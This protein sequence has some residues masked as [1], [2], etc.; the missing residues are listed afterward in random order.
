VV[1]SVVHVAKSEVPGPYLLDGRE[2]G[3]ITA[4]LFHAGGHEDPARLKANEG[5]SFI[6]SY[7]L[8]MGFTFDD[9]DTKGVAT[10]LA[11]MERLIRK[12]PRNRE[13]VFPSIG[14]EEVNDSP[15]HAHQFRGLSAAPRKPRAGMGGGRRGP[16]QGV[17]ARWRCAGGLCWRA[18][19]MRSSRTSSKIWLDAVLRGRLG[20]V[21]SEPLA[22]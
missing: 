20:S 8:G 10:P 21:A 2:V 18:S 12:D 13:R 9:T 1:V 7:V 19:A 11:E 5:K 15:T 14:G 16:V 6:G 22:T 17:A 3:I 4:Y